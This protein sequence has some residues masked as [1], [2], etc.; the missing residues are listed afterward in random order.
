MEACISRLVHTPHCCPILALI[1]VWAIAV[2][3]E[4]RPLAGKLL[5]PSASFEEALGD[6]PTQYHWRGLAAAVSLGAGGEISIRWKGGGE[7][8]INFP[9]A[10]PRSEPHGEAKSESKTRYYLG[11]AN[12]WRTASHFERVRYSAIYPGI[13]L[14]FL[15]ASNQIEYNFEISP[16]ADPDAI[17][18]RYIGST[19]HLTGNGDL[20]IHAGGATITQLHPIAFENRQGRMHRIAC[21]YRLI[22]SQEANLRLG[23]HDPARPLYIDPVLNFSTYLGGSLYDSINAA[24]ND[25][26]GNLYVAGTTGSG[27]LTNPSLPPRSSNDVFVAKFASVGTLVSLVYLG[28]SGLDSG[29]G[30]A[31]DPL[32]NIYVTGMTTSTDFP[33]TNGAFST[34]APGGGDAFVAK[35]SPSF[36]LQYS[37]YLG[38]PGADSGSAIAV[39]SSGAVYVAGQ[40]ASTDFPV[41]QGGFETSFQGGLSDCFVSKLNQAGSALVHSTYL[42]GSALDLCAGIAVDAS[43]N[44]Y[45]AG[46]TYSSNFPVVESL[47]NSLLGTATAFVAKIN[48]AGTSLIYSTYLGG[49]NIDNANAIALDSSDAAYVTGDTASF[50]FPVT[51]GVVQ[52]GLNGLYN[53]FVSKLSAAGNTLVYS[54]LLGGSGSDRGTSIAIDSAGRAIIGGYTT[55]SNFPTVDAIQASFQGAVDAFS[56]V[57]DPAGANLVFSSYFGG[58]GVDMGYAVALGPD[59]Q[60]YLAG[61]TS[62]SN[63]PIAMA[64]QP[65]LSVAPDAFVLEVTYIGGEPAAVSATPG[66]GTGSSPTF[67]LEY[68]DSSGVASLQLVYV[69]FSASLASENNSCM[70]YYSPATNQVSLLNDAGSAWL[71]ATPGA[72][73]T[74]L[75]NSQCLLN[76]A[77]TTVNTGGNTLTLN[78]AMMFKPAYAGSRNVYLYA[79]DMSGLSSGWQQHGT[80]DVPGSAEQIRSDFNG[81]GYS[82]IIWQNPVSGAS[83]VYYLDGAQGTTIL[84][85]GSFTGANSWHIV[86]VADFNL[87]GH[88]DLVWQDPTT[89]ESQIWFMGGAQGTTVLG[90]V[91]VTSANSWRIVAA[92]DFNL[93]GHPDLVW[94]DPVSGHAQIWYLAGP[95]GA[96]LTGAANLTLTN[97]WNIVGASDFNGDGHPDIVWQDPVSGAVQVWYLSG[98]QGNVVSSAA[99]LLGQGPGTIVA[100]ADFNL[101]G[102]PDIA[103]QEPVSG[104]SQVWFLGGA[105]G[106]TE[107]GTSS[108]GSSIPLSI[109]GPR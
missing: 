107:L 2:H 82:D 33:V 38:G 13:D 57:L 76:V 39:D 45:V 109:V 40:T 21:D 28:G 18:I 94:Q 32:G 9:G 53:A 93:D 65:A 43:G 14:V 19:G 55:S 44:A 58:S 64:I 87:D 79:V 67:A 17:R 85:T 6:R 35:F 66:S 30:I 48:A 1:S 91:P 70:L 29:Q 95:Q 26:Q 96:T 75:Q 8:H 37:T 25:S 46:T 41:I 15:A 68:S 83:A 3:A 56:T 80:W 92:S 63:F 72:P 71:A 5:Q 78:L 23:A 16:Y 11:V 105:Q 102:H 47:Q 77:T 106:V 24:T 27:S 100:I 51:P 62:S 36:D 108:M 73:M 97:T 12:T 89:G 103:W 98:P 81:A 31:L 59:S 7:A 84:G 69:V 22:G 90:T 34:Q 52:T 104:V 99:E 49:S 88:P 42:G 50:D 61:T 10:N 60:L 4:G 86:A 54:T 101:D 74:L 20:E